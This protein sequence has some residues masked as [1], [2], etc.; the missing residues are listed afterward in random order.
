MNIVAPLSEIACYGGF[1]TITVG[2][3][4]RGWRPVQRCYADGCED[5][6]DI[7]VDRYRS[8]D[9]RIAASTVQLS[10]ASRLWSPVLACALGFGVVPDL[11]ELYRK[12][13]STALR[14][15][16]AVAAPVVPSADALYQVVVEQHL[17]PLADG[18]R[19]KLARGLL[20]GNA[21]SAL[22]AASRALI[23]ARPDLQPGIVAMTETL[24]ATGKLTGTGILTGPV[25]Q[26][27]RRSCCLYYRASG[28]AK[29]HDCGL[30]RTA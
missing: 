25:L 27:R 17:E 21:A 18:L 15:A 1:F 10:H 20:Y 23:T 5:L 4:D 2:G 6:I 16:H 9:R 26:F 24:L 22:V 28:G 7:T 8:R 11:T 13:D 29:C 12:D 30:K 19:V 14:L 3:D